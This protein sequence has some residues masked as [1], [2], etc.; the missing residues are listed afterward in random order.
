M[1]HKDMLH[2]DILIEEFGL[3]N[4]RCKGDFIRWVATMVAQPMLK[5]SMLKG[6]LETTEEFYDVVEKVKNAN[7]ELL[8]NH[9]NAILPKI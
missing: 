8:E 4:A 7:P 2:K 6:S 3:Q 1:L 9:L 5:W